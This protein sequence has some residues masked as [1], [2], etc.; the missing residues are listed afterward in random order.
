MFQV[1]HFRRGH[2]GLIQLNDG[3]PYEYVQKIICEFKQIALRYKIYFVLCTVTDGAIMLNNE[4][5]AMKYVLESAGWKQDC[6]PD[7]PQTDMWLCPNK[8]R[9]MTFKDASA[10]HLAT[11]TIM[12]QQNVA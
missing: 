5:V 9:W 10:A 3:L 6:D 4:C 11:L 8:K 1:H 2:I 12:G 7:G